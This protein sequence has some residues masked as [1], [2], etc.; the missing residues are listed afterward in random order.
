[1]VVYDHSSSDPATV[2]ADSFLGV[3][4]LKLRQSF[5]SVHLLSGECGVGASGEWKGG[6]SQEA[7]CDL[8]LLL[9]RRLLQV[10]Q[11]VPRPV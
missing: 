5:L 4:L 2:S 3:L 8:S 6:A 7:L 11:S 9:F 1:M 10:L